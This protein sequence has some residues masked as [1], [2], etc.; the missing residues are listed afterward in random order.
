MLI[1]GAFACGLLAIVAILL[2]S[3]G[4]LA[5]KRTRKLRFI[6]VALAYVL[7]FTQAVYNLAVG[8]LTL[9]FPVHVEFI[10]LNLAIVLLF[11]LAMLK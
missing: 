2:A 10:L 3:L 7:F 8:L 1:L 11:Y 9:D 4:L 6:F 5:Y